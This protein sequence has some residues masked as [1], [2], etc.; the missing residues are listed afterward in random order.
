MRNVR[1][2]FKR[3]CRENFKIIDEKD[4][5]VPRLIHYEKYK[6]NRIGFRIPFEFEV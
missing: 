4:I 2:Q 5:D 3:R 6:G 1:K